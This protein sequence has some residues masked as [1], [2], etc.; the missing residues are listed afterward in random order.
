M[1]EV[2]RANAG[3]ISRELEHQ[4]VLSPVLSSFC[5]SVARNVLLF[6]ETPS[7]VALNHDRPSHLPPPRHEAQNVETSPLPD[8][9]LPAQQHNFATPSQSRALS[10]CLDASPI[11]A[12]SASSGSSPCSDAVIALTD[13]VLVTDEG[14]DMVESKALDTS[15]VIWAAAQ[16]HGASAWTRPDDAIQET[17]ATAVSLSDAIVSPPLLCAAPSAA[18]QIQLPASQDCLLDLQ[19][20]MHSPQQSLPVL[21][22]AVADSYSFDEKADE[23]T[24]H[25]VPLNVELTIS[26]PVVTLAIQKLQLEKVRHESQVCGQVDFRAWE[27]IVKCCLNL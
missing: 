5:S 16:A 20:S 6:P 19:A 11:Y 15:V 10:P 3:G 26:S 9:S 8:V 18:V 27:S 23:Q 14:R 22:A 13:V 4:R 24:K 1:D 2:H 7:V 21:A 25:V 17:S 12:N